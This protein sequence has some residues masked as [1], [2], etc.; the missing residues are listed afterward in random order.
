MAQKTDAALSTNQMKPD[1]NQSWLSHFP[2]P[3]LQ[4]I[5]SALQRVFNGFLWYFPVLWLAI[6]ITFSF[7][8]KKK[9]ISTEIAD[10]WLSVLSCLSC[11]LFCCFLYP[12]GE[13]SSIDNEVLIMLISYLCLGDCF[14]TLGKGKITIM[15]DSKEFR[16]GIHRLEW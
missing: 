1:L 15:E 3:V 4:G 14:Q 5:C 7:Y 12:H 8:W 16:K 13:S 11:L 9:M 10:R 2:F 6:V